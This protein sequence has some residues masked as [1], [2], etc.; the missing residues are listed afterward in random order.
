MK[1]DLT[2]YF[3]ILALCGWLIGI[4]AVRQVRMVQSRRLTAY[5][6]GM[7]TC[8]G[9]A[10][11]PNYVCVEDNVF[12]STGRFDFA[13]AGVPSTPKVRAIKG[14]M[15]DFNGNPSKD[16]VQCESGTMNARGAITSGIGCTTVKSLATPRICTQEPSGDYACTEE[17]R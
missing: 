5:S 13:N 8:E 2:L 17:R 1:R 10:P 11:G 16:Y 4:A 12:T 6:S 7:V 15:A 9:P 3:G 14:P